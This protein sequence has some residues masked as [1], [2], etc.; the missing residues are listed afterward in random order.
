MQPRGWRGPLLLV[1]KHNHPPRDQSTPL[2]TLLLSRGECADDG[3]VRRRQMNPGA[4]VSN[5]RKAPP[6]S[7]EVR[8]LVTNF[9]ISCTN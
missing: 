5:L 1:S 4:E 8:G 6:R 3:T 7:D 2:A 9:G